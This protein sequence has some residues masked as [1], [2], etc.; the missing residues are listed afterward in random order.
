VKGDRALIAG[1]AAK[2]ALAGC[3]ITGQWSGAGRGYVVTA[4]EAEDISAWASISRIRYSHKKQ[5]T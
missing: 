2:D 5:D 1:P 4:V 3:F